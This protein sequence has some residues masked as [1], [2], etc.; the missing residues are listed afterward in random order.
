MIKKSL[1][2]F[3]SIFLFSCS[4]GIKSRGGFYTVEQNPNIMQ[5]TSF[6][7]AI[8]LPTSGSYANA[9]TGM[10]NAA[11]MALEDSKNKN[12]TLYFYDTKSTAQGARIAIKN[13]QRQNPNLIIG[14][15]LS[16]NLEAIIDDVDNDIPLISFATNPEILG[17]NIY[18]IGLLSE[19]QVDR[20][21]AFTSSLGK[22]KYG[23]LLPE[24]NTGHSTL[25]S[26]EKAAQKYGVEILST[27]FYPPQTTDFSSILKEM[28]NYEK[29]KNVMN[30]Y[31]D[32]LTAKAQAGD[33]IAQRK[34]QRLG[35]N[36]AITKT[37]FDA[38]LIADGGA[39]LKSAIS[40]F[41]YYDITY[42]NVLF[43]GTSI[44]EGSNLN[45]EQNAIGGMYPA[46]SKQYSKYFNS[47]YQ[48]VFGQHPSTLYTLA[49]DAIAL[50]SKLSRAQD[51][52]LAILKKD[53]Y[54]GL[55]GAF[56]FLENGQSEHV[57]DIYQVKKDTNKIIDF[58]PKSF[59]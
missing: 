46:L 22:Q 21:F 57:L 8:L 48:Q 43:F 33:V 31:K 41:G 25:K 51:I 7:I 19:N 17:N 6:K 32:S 3:F 45:N 36:D 14:P 10:K 24:N 20:M 47:K 28:T 13:A 55:N 42:P 49:Y 56:R 11:Q 38:I 44:W 9:G 12:L 34:L 30:S 54:A 50:A 58:A 53:G 23:L 5:P 4:S 40:M 1:V 27:T 16:T 37:D 59:Q 29:R 15:L 18:S 39:K 2:L 52:N 26:A 35:D